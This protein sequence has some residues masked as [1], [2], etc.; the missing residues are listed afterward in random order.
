MG[1]DN[2]IRYQAKPNFVHRKV[3]GNDVLI[4]IAENVACFNGFIELNPAAAF[5]WDS[6]KEP[7]NADEITTSHAVEFGIDEATA[8]TDTNEFLSELIEHKMIT[9]VR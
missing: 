2:N 8:Q 6:L 3:G 1:I 4:P 5:I 7:V 9:E